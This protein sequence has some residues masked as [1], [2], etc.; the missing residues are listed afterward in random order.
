MAPTI[1]QNKYGLKN[2]T[3]FAVASCERLYR[4][5]GPFMD[6]SLMRLNAAYCRFPCH[7]PQPLVGS[8]IP[9]RVSPCRDGISMF[10]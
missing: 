7:N 3:T 10:R 1:A 9:G 8:V 2:A 6:I 4:S 5:W